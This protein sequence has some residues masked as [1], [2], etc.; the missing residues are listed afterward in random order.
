MSGMLDKLR[1]KGGEGKP[2]PGYTQKIGEFRE[3]HTVGGLLNWAAV[4]AKSRT[5]LNK[6]ASLITVVGF[7]GPDMESSTKGELVSYISQLNGIIKQL[8]TGYVLY[9]D[10]QRHVANGYDHSH[11]DIPL[12]QMMDDE[13]AEYYDGGQ[14]Y[15]TSFY[16]VLNQEAPQELKNRIMNAFIEDA[17]SEGQNDSLKVLRDYMNKFIA[18]RDGIVSILSKIMPYVYVLDAEE[19][20]T[21]LHDTISPNR[22]PVKVCPDLFLSDYLF[23]GDGLTA[24]TDMRIGHKYTKLVTIR[25]T[26]PP[27]SA[28]GFLDVLNSLNMEYR[29]VSRFSC[30][31]KP[32]AQKQLE[33]IQRNWT[34]AAKSMIAMVRE[35]IMPETR[36][37]TQ[38]DQSA[39]QDAGD[40]ATALLELN[41]DYVG[42]GYYTMT[43]QVSDDSKDL[44]REKAARIEEVLQTHGFSAFTETFNSMEA[45]WGSLPGHHRANIRR[46]LV[47]T[48]TF[49]HFLPVTALWPGDQRN[50]FLKGPV[51]LYTD[52]NGF[53]PFRL[54]LHVGEVG[55][56]MVVGPTGAGKSVFL[57]TIE[58]HFLKY[59]NSQV[60]IF[61]KAAS[62]RAL[63][64]AVGGNFYNLAAEGSGE[65]SFQPLAGIDDD[66]E[67]RWARSWVIDFLKSKNIVMGPKE[68]RAVWDAVMALRDF[69]VEQRTITRFC[70]L[71]Q[72]QNLRL[73]LESLTMSGSYGKL[74]DNNKDVS[75][76]G[77]WQVFEMETIMG[78]ADVVPPTLDYLFHRIEQ[79]INK[80]TGPSIIVM[81]ECWLFMSNKTFAE[82]LREYLKDM[83][84][85]NTSIIIATQN[86]SDIAKA[87]VLKDVVKEQCP[88]KIF[89]P[90]VNATTGSAI[91]LYEDFGLNNQQIML[92]RSMIPK[93]DYYYNSQKGNRIF[94]LS[95]R[96]AELPFVTATSKQDQQAM[97]RILAEYPEI[98][99]ENKREVFIRE[100]FKHKG[101]PEEWA[102][103][104]KNNMKAQKATTA[105]KIGSSADRK[106]VVL[107]PATA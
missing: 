96:K 27:Q 18:N 5:V 64:L 72:D 76:K 23:D 51:L 43:I 84:K 19:L 60:F 71:V 3:P 28:P 89:L 41:Q 11:M 74:F 45:W 26:F 10:A 99:G 49:C 4:D 102:K 83:R 42:Y 37:Q 93:Q 46:A 39:L 1:G 9:F 68:E 31:S 8:P 104:V 87:E 91:A 98:L 44:C 63:T 17:E 2:W 62:S 36:G 32:D 86:L 54:S 29:W 82:K 69:S 59:P 85:K 81:D 88:S 25:S 97:N 78:Q 103:Y 50:F 33:E 13:R 80:A 34:Q 58:A 66:N 90:N 7:R 75:G 15:E 65:L 70:E 77:R 38:L 30:L 52:T 47:S 35:A 100:W 48:L 12:A 16:L 53:T 57:N 20:V 95:L 105:N 94:R 101:F 40:A 21:Y 106:P 14:H 107:N 73:G 56:T 92:V 24:G 55:H 79:L 22:H 6:D 61:D 67:A